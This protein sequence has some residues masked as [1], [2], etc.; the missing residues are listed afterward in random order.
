MYVVYFYLPQNVLLIVQVKEVSDEED[1]FKVHVTDDIEVGGETGEPSSGE[2]GEIKGE[3]EREREKERERGREIPI[4]IG[5]CKMIYQK[6]YR[7]CSCGY[8]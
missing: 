5:A 2:E 7:Q 4:H 3:R 6:L 8:S 1:E